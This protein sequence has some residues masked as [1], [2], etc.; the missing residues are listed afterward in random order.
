MKFIKINVFFKNTSLHLPRKKI[1][2]LIDP[3]F[4]IQMNKTITMRVVCIIIVFF[5][6]DLV[7]MT[8]LVIYGINPTLPNLTRRCR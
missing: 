3:T 1:H 8:R 5:F 2:V 7:E 4:N 6:F